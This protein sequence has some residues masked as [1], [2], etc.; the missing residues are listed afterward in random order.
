MKTAKLLDKLGRLVES[1]ESLGRERLKKL[2]KMVRELKDK[3]KKLEKELRKETD[4]ELRHNIQRSIEVVRTQRKK[5][6]AVYKTLKRSPP[7]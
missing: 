1:P 5:G 2:R 7:E 3:Q 6:A 4:E